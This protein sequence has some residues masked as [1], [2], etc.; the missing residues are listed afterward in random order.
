MKCPGNTAGKG[1][2]ISYHQSSWLMCT[3]TTGKE[4]LASTLII[5]LPVGPKK[6]SALFRE[7]GG[8]IRGREKVGVVDGHWFHPTKPENTIPPLW[9][10]GMC[11]IEYTGGLIRTPFYPDLIDSFMRHQL[12]LAYMEA[13]DISKLPRKHLFALAYPP[14][15]ILWLICEGINS[16]QFKEPVSIP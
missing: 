7:M 12:S 10:E 11:C 3:I 5:S 4:Y 9:D 14:L 8:V 15:F 6:F 13:T 2:Y 1:R 16:I